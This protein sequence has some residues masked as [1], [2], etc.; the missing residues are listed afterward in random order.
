MLNLVVWDKKV[1]GQ[2]SF[3]RSQHELIGVFRV[4]RAAHL[5]NIELG[6]FGRNRTN[7]WAHQGCNSFGHHRTASLSMHPTIKPT[8]LVTDALLD[9]T[10]RGDAV[11]DHFAGSGTLFLACERVSRKAFGMEIEP[12]Y[13]DLAVQRWQKMTKLEATLDGDGRTFDELAELRNSVKQSTVT[14]LKKP[15]S[16]KRSPRHG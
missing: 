11:L 5:N 2:G 12:R 14:T 1:G 8:G 7:I 15:R 9:C 6:R 3:Y 13:V 4:G 16:G 10:Q